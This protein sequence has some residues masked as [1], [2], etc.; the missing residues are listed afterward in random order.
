MTGVQTCALP[1]LL[2]A[3]SGTFSKGRYPVT[4]L[5]MCAVVEI[6]GVSRCAGLQTIMI[7]AFEF[8][9]C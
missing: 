7:D 1:I 9:V 5:K 6:V 3:M 2:S 8:C 4:V